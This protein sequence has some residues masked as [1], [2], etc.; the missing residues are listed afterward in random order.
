MTKRE[1][2]FIKKARKLILAG[3]GGERLEN[4]IIRRSRNAY[5]YRVELGSLLRLIEDREF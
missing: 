1:L 3:K 2:K 5:N 4:E